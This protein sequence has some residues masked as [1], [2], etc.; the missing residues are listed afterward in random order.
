MSVEI[1]LSFRSGRPEYLETGAMTLTIARLAAHALHATHFAFGLVG[2]AT[3]VA[4]PM[5]ST[6]SSRR[7]AMARLTRG[8]DR[9]V[10]AKKEVE[11]GPR[12]PL[13]IKINPGGRGAEGWP[14][15]MRGW[16]VA[17]W[18]GPQLPTRRHNP[19]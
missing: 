8:V 11:R 2:A 13:Q 6:S 15:L 4:I 17:V 18:L 1:G 14:G 16:A 12:L 7:E 10:E 5:Q 9:P 3:T 19:G